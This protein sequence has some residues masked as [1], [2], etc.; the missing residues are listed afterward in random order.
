[1][2]GITINYIIERYVPFG[3]EI[4]YVLLIMAFVLGSACLGFPIALLITRKSMNV[5]DNLNETIN[6]IAECD[7]KKHNDRSFSALIF[8]EAVL[9]PTM[10]LKA[11]AFLVSRQK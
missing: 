9:R 7:F 3:T 11:F 6:K 5:L 10:R 4:Q 2:V 8:R 1:M